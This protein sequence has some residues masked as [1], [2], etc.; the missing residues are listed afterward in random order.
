MGPTA[1]MDVLEKRK[2]PCPTAI[3]TGDRRSCTQY[4][5]RPDTTPA[6][7]PSD[8]TRRQILKYGQAHVACCPVLYQLRP[9]ST[10]QWNSSIQN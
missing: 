2:I 8:T 3:R 1:G 4:I 10:A 6:T 7:H 5:P 9:E